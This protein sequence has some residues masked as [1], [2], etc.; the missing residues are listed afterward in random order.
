M[1]TLLIDLLLIAAVFTLV[2]NQHRAEV[3]LD[4]LD[5]KQA[6]A[7]LDNYLSHL[8]AMLPPAPPNLHVIARGTAEFL[9]DEPFNL[10][11]IRDQVQIYGD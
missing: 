4:E 1:L 9:P 8:E 5:Q 7:V 11:D 10:V 3:R 6:E 2:I